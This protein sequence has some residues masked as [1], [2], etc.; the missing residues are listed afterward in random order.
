MK[1]SFNLPVVSS[2]R[3]ESVRSWFSNP[4]LVLSVATFVLAT[5]VAWGVYDAVPHLEDE[6][7]FFYQAKVFATG[8]VINPAPPHYHAFYTPFVIH[9]DGAVFS[10]YPPGYSLLLALGVSLGQPWLVNALAAAL[11]ILGTYLLGRDL[12]GRRTGLL[13]AGLGA[14]SP[15]YILLSGTLLSHTTTLA[16]LTFFAWA[17]LRA[18]RPD[19][20]QRLDFALLA[21]ALV[22]WALISRPFTAMAIG[23]PFALL[24]AWDFI[25]SP[26]AYLPV[27]LRMGLAFGLVCSLLPMYNYAATGSPVTNTYRLWWPYDSAGFG[28]EYGPGGHNLDKAL[29]NLRVDFPVFG[30]TLLGWPALFG[31][32]LQWPV[33]ALGVLLA[34][35][36][37]AAW[38]LLGLG[39]ALVV[40]HLAYWAHSGGLYGPRYYAEGMPFLWIL[41]AHGL[42]KLTSGGWAAQH[43]WA[44]Q[45]LRL[46]LVQ[47]FLPLAIVWGILFVTFPRFQE[48][49]GLYDI[50]RDDL[51]AIHNYGIENA[52][53]FV[54]DRYWTD[55]ANLSWLNTPRPE[56]GEIIFARDTGEP[57]N[58]EVIQTFPGRAIYYYNRY[59]SQPL[60][61]ARSNAPELA[62]QAGGQTNWGSL[63]LGPFMEIWQQ[64]R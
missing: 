54:H 29:L 4:I 58:Q 2:A 15:M 19:E 8:L 57:G 34:W 38:A 14:L 16:L 28:P 35:R 41:A 33:I 10:K 46:R 37:K 59:E 32:A 50:S 6:H 31:V 12:F 7:A 61:A 26:R 45:T 60:V 13:A 22:G 39:F 20:P 63:I 40:A 62:T 55:Y 27:A 43:Q 1:R 49:R 3:G 64:R 17:F 9:Q 5:A 18:R 48:A 56:N 42:V 25:R 36:R 24:A 11:G 44:A 30:Q 23:L 21:G 47:A 51:I 52:L 53:V